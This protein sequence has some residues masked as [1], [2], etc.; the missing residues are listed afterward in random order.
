MFRL[1]RLGCALAISVVAVAAA[2]A[3]DPPRM[4]FR[5][6]PR[7]ID[8]IKASGWTQ[9]VVQGPMPTDSLVARVKNE[10]IERILLAALAKK[11]AVEVD[12]T[13]K[14]PEFDVVAVT[15]RI[16]G[17]GSDKGQVIGLYADDKD[18]YKA[19]V[20]YGKNVDVWTKEPRMQSILEMAVALGLPVQE[21]TYD[22]KTMEITRGKLNIEL[23]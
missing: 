1:T 19:T 9:V 13:G 23:K 2:T 6:V 11:Y 16:P 20:V 4:K 3:A 21:F 12:Y 7:D 14:D 15:L 22:E 5:G 10:R 8:F 17:G 18:A